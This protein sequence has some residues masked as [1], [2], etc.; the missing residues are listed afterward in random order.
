MTPAIKQTFHNLVTALDIAVTQKSA[1]GAIGP[2]ESAVVKP[3]LEALL[4]GRFHF[5]AEI[6]HVTH[7]TQQ[8]ALFPAEMLLR[9][10]TPL[11]Q[12]IPP[13][14]PINII[15][16]NSLHHLLDKAI[17]VSAI[18]QALRKDQM[19]I[20]INTSARNLKTEAF[21]RDI[22]ALIDD[23][24]DH[25]LI[26][27]NL[28][29]EVTEDDLAHNPCREMLLS[30]KD[31]YECKFAIDDFYYDYSHHAHNQSGIDSFDWGRLQNLKDIIDFVKID[32]EIVE[33]GLLGASKQQ[34]H[35]LVSRVHSVAPHAHFV[36][37][38]VADADEALLLGRIV[39]GQTN[40]RSHAAVQG[41]RLLPDR[42][43]FYETL[44][45]ATLN[46]PP[47]PKGLTR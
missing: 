12:P 42:E 7:E 13:L 2:E 18:D 8:K 40:A 4:S 27:G 36:F 11:M 25:H 10:Y 22:G 17:I 41:R 28:T 26:R 5:E 29:F 47:R 21:W 6:W 44:I 46:F 15:A 35:E 31:K 20:S 23:H 19:P 16:Q 24:F 33:Q 14:A 45:D 3:L 39:N 43:Q 30:I 1:A 9:A 32:G 38:R 34:L 37:E